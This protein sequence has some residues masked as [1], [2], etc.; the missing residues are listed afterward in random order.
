MSRHLGLGSLA[1][2]KLGKNS[3]HSGWFGEAWRF[4]AL[5][6]RAQSMGDRQS[7]ERLIDLALKAFDAAEEASDLTNRLRRSNRC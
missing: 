6:D 4:L 1:M 3:T 2:G 5:A 7:A